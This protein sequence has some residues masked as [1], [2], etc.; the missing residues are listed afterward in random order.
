MKILNIC[1]S[2]YPAFKYGGPI[3]SVHLLNK[4]L[5]KKGIFVSVLTT[6]AGLEDRKDISV[7]KWINL[8]GVNV[9]Y[10]K[11]CGYEHY[12]FSLNYLFQTIKEVKKFDIIYIPA[13]WN[14][15]VLIGSIASILFKKPF[16]I[17]PRGSLYEETFKIKSK[18]KKILY[19]YLFAKHY[20]AKATAIHFTAEPEKEGFFSYFK[21][22]N[23]SFII[24]N[25]IDLSEF[26][27]LPCKGSFVNKYHMLK[28]KKYIL[29]LGRITPKKGID[30][31]VE[32]FKNLSQEYEELCL[33]IA[34]PNNEEYEEKIRLM[35]KELKIIEKVLFVGIL[36]GEEKI[37]AFVDSE[38]FVLSS[39]SENFGMA[40][41]EAMACGV[42][43]VISN[44]VGIY[45]EIE[46]NKA[47]V[48]VDITPKS[49]Y[50][51]IR[52]LLSDENLK[53]ETAIRGKRFVEN[54]YNIDSVADMMIKSYEEILN[55][56]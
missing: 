33:V 37:S 25:G 31:L 13:I 48:I 38:I 1:P 46:E 28:G 54:Y 52:L 56:F 20:I 22:N 53:K 12:N 14:F 2:Y 17:S 35:I 45:K 4:I 49:I 51:G 44:K 15:P 39:Y 36:K 26:K 41:I 27:N 30:I 6:N 42:P 34:G 19:Y 11:Y 55:K 40:V 18:N 23:R 32:A 9:K 50:N 21:L 47:G 29:F 7:N 16:I 8:E 5:A 10:I 24:P 43:V 3:Q